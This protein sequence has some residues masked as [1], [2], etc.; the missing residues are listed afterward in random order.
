MLSVQDP[1]IQARDRCLSPIEG[2][3]PPERQ[4]GERVGD[5]A[6]RLVALL[7]TLILLQ[8]FTFEKEI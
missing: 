7:I 5:R 3:Q 8:I 2:W 1:D 4:L 6:K